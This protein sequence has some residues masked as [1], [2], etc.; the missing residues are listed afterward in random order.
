MTNVRAVKRP[1]RYVAKHWLLLL[2]PLFTY[3]F[4]R[5]AYVLRGVGRHF[6]PVL[7]CERRTHRERDRRPWPDR[8]W[9]ELPR[10]LQASDGVV[11]RRRVRA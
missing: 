6:G 4:S 2:R 9:R 7:R 10:G 11:E 1:R 8:P 3:N 5:D